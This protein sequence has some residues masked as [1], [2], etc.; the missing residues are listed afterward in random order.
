MKRVF[1]S[2]ELVPTMEAEASRY[3]TLLMPWIQK[4]A[5]IQYFGTDSLLKVSPKILNQL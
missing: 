3:S 5:L 1:D 2:I 4:Y